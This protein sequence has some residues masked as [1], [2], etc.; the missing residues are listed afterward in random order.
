MYFPK[1]EDYMQ[2]LEENEIFSCED[3]HFIGFKYNAPTT[4]FHYWNDVT[5]N[6]RGI[7]FDKQTG[8]IVARPFYKFFNYQ[9]LINGEGQ[10]TDILDKVEACG[11]R[12]DAT[13]S[14]R[15]MDK[16]DGSLG[17][18]FYDK[19]ADKWRVKT[20]GSFSSDQAVWGQK[21]FDENVNLSELVKGFTYCFEIIY[22]ED[23][24]PISYEKEEM[25]LLGICENQSGVE[26]TLS[27]L[28][29]AG[30]ALGVRVADIIEFKNFDEVIPYATN[31]PNTKEGVVVTFKNGFK[32]KIKGKEFLE[33][34]RKFH[35]MTEDFIWQHFD[36][37]T[38]KVPLDIMEAIPEEMPDLKRYAE[39]LET[40]Y[41]GGCG[42]SFTLAHIMRETHKGDRRKI[43]EEVSKG[44]EAM[45]MKGLTAAVMRCVTLLEHGETL[46]DET[47][48]DSVREIV[49]KTL[50]P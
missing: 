33:L 39:V 36:I 38:G 1:L 23:V 17:I 14:F 13:Q 32:V 29:D 48:P 43:Y 16:L 42:M 27:A 8:E 50:K 26:L 49:Y 7:V 24:H 40:R 6:A 12:L 21:W 19:Y 44:M 22:N 9:E 35:N 2:K 18:V 34:Q 3:E 10:R 11:W 28:Q 20:G 45:H 4:Y 31:L 15:V 5:L 46:T 30:K 37:H 47:L 25:V 41:Y